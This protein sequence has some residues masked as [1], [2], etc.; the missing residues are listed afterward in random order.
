MLTVGKSVYANLF[1]LTILNL[2]DHTKSDNFHSK[3]FFA[4][5]YPDRPFLAGFDILDRWICYG[6]T[7]VFSMCIFVSILE[8][9]KHIA[10]HP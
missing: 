1:F 2:Y 7:S 8:T 3:R 9:K 10:L 6:H 5:I 4:Q